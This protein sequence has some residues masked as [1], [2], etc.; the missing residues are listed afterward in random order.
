MVH[1]CSGSKSHSHP[2][3]QSIFGLGGCIW[4]WS[5]VSIM[6]G[7]HPRMGQRDFGNTPNSCRRIFVLLTCIMQLQCHETQQSYD[8]DSHG[9]ISVRRLFV[10]SISPKMKVWPRLLEPDTDQPGRKD[11]SDS[12]IDVTLQRTATTNEWKFYIKSSLRSP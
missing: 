10:E 9:T 7:L 5:I 12:V 4:G 3:W 6:F 11:S 2:T 1:S 8:Y